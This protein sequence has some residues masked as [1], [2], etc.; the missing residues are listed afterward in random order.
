MKPLFLATL[1]SVGVFSSLI[2][3]RARADE[4]P[5]YNSNWQTVQLGGG[6][7]VYPAAS[8]SVPLAA[9]YY[10]KNL[11]I[12]AEGTTA[13]STIEVMVNGQVKGTIQAP[14]HD[15]SFVV[16]VAET[17]RSIEF[18][19]RDG[20]TMRII[21]IV[22]TIA[23]VPAQPVF[24]GGFVGSRDALVALANK[25]LRQIDNLDSFAEPEDENTYLFPIK[26]NAGLVYVMAT[27][28]GDLSRQ[29]VSQLVALSD[30]I[31]FADSYLNRLMMLDAAFDSVVEL[32]SVKETIR[33]IL[34]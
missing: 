16:T 6:F 12:Q 34:Q 21:S 26:R 19:H 31:A 33:S 10:I 23:E 9:P 2:T 13:G 17:A 22:G 24:G 15:P 18:R 1:L 29:T 32:L 11:V 14:G 7:F 25:A 30:Q 20:G 27:A 28:H 8:E 3:S 5:V 4:H